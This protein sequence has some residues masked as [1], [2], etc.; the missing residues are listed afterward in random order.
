MRFVLILTVF[1]G[2][3]FA[4]I[5]PGN[6]V[7]ELQGVPMGNMARSREVSAAAISRRA[8]LDA[9]QKSMRTFV[10]AR[11]GKVLGSMRNII[12][13]IAINIPEENAAVL[14]T[15]PGVKRVFPASI[16]MPDLDH[17]LPLH[18]VPQAWTQ[19]GG[20]S[21]AGLGMKIG[22]LDTGITPGHPAFQDPTLTPPPGYPIVSGPENLP[23][24]NNKIIVARNYASY[25]QSATPDS[26]IDL[27]GHGTETAD[28]AAGVTAVGPFA[29]V[30]GV[31]PKAFLGIY[32][33]TSLDQENASS[34]VIAAALDDAFGDGMDVISMSFG[35]SV[36][37]YSSLQQ[38][39]LERVTQ[40][41]VLVVLS[42]GNAGPNPNT[43]GD[44]AD[45]ESV[46]A[47]GATQSDREFAGA[48]MASG[49]N[50]IMGFSGDYSKPNPPLTAGLSDMSVVDPVNLG[51]G[52]ALPAK[53]L[54]G[55][56]VVTRSTP[57]CYYQTILNNAAAAGAVGVILYP[58]VAG[59]PGSAFNPLAATLPAVY[60]SH[61][62]GLTLKGLATSN[63]VA[64]V[65]FEGFAV[66]NESRVLAGFS[67][68]GPIE[69][70]GLKPDLAATGQ[71]VYM[72]TQTA[73]P[74]GGLY[75][76]SGFLQQSGTSFS[77]PMVA[78]AAALVKQAHPGLTM[79]QYRSLLINSTNPLMLPTGIPEKL[80][81]TGAGVLNV[82]SALS[83]TVAVY[84]TSLSLYTGGAT[85]TPA[86]DYA[87]LTITNVGTQTE[88]FTASTIPYD[89]LPAPT[90]SKDG[91]N[92][93]LGQAGTNQVSVTL[94]PKRSQVL[95]VSWSAKSLPVGEYQGQIVVRGGLTGSTAVVPYW[96]AYPDGIPNY[97]D[98]LGA[99]TQA[100]AG[101]VVDLY[102]KVK[103][104]TG[105]AIL[106]T[107]LINATSS[108]V[109]G[110]GKILGPYFSSSY[111]NWLYFAATLSTTPGDNT[112][113]FQAQG[114][115]PV[116]Y[117]ITGV[118]PAVA[119]STG[120][121][122]PS[123]SRL[124]PA[125]EGGNGPVHLQAVEQR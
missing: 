57:L 81:R 6:Y 37:L 52:T 120:P 27:F 46:I 85:L 12:N 23:V 45:T 100:T 48:V 62:D 42:A 103:D 26:A 3:G 11:G 10:E 112:F 106:N 80:Q 65:T 117:T 39:I 96:Y 15:M 104:G 115:A 98:T 56:V 113:T 7:I 73:N 97:I 69:G 93:Y 76:S 21:K 54:T 4:Q 83:S 59:A 70:G 66:P 99:P 71:Y 2:S 29:I 49:I 28:C 72:A 118:K 67:S 87:L 38:Y 32:K 58:S 34:A 114:F 109:S 125:F 25:Y 89:S 47:V 92:V 108:V 50:T 53:S 16:A 121:A 41:G 5:I 35:S 22:V 36:Q 55:T 116:T 94:G 1:I 14:A 43:I 84:P 40:A 31:A 51:C 18:K 33:I 105:A 124:V 111:V 60:V 101:G 19:L 68:R 74:N 9:E 78:G 119:T 24:V 20:M 17:A 102:F 64:T 95:Y 13:A 88:V 75:H 44:G 82:S 86:Q 110:G 77:A 123:I 107:R 61:A 30:T 90:F 8:A 91:S 63:T 79:D 122:T